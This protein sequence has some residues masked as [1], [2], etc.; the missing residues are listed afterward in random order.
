MKHYEEL[1]SK[2]GQPSPV[3]YSMEQL[4]TAARSFGAQTLGV[5][6]SLDN[7][8]RRPNRFVCIALLKQG[9]FVNVYDI[10]EDRVYFADPPELRQAGLDAFRSIWTGRARCHLGQADSG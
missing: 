1:E 6:T 8:V 2:L 7:L 10:A 9:H 3:G 5:E 4:A